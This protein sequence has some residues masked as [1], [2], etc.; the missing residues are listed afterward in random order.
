MSG[1]GDGNRGPVVIAVIIVGAIILGL[2]LIGYGSV[3]DRENKRNAPKLYSEISDLVPKKIYI[4][5]TF[6][7]KWDV[8]DGK[9]YYYFNVTDENNTFLRLRLTQMPQG[10]ETQRPQY[11]DK[12]MKTISGIVVKV[13]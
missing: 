11:S 3:I 12:I 10:C 7:E 8:W 4:V 2:I 6:K 1:N 13:P 5:E 9:N